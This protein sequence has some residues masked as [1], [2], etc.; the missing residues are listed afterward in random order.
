MYTRFHPLFHYMGSVFLSINSS[1]SLEIYM[2]A[3]KDFKCI[4]KLF[5]DKC[6]SFKIL[7]S[8]Q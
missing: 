7:D 2:L 5:Q 1:L 6:L 8:S 4:L 3:H